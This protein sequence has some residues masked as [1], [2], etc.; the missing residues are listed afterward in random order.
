MQKYKSVQITLHWFTLILVIAIFATIYLSDVFPSPLRS[1]LKNAHFMLGV[2]VW[3]VVVIRLI[4]R[5]MFKAPPI[6]P[7][8]SR[9]QYIAS[10]SIHDIIYVV[11][12]AQ[13][14]L[15]VIFTPIYIGRSWSF[16]GAPVGAIFNF[17]EDLSYKLREVHE[18]IGIIIMLLV[19]LHAAAALY[20]HFIKRDN[21]LLRML[22]THKKR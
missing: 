18:F 15:G 20:H 8:L 22:P 5:V 10:R 21:T 2:I 11:F 1:M 7:P 9:V 16:L 19:G 12:L 13:P 3:F 14:I 17:S 4:L 6:E